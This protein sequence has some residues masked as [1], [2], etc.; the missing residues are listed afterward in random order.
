MTAAEEAAP[1]ARA[2][3]AHAGPDS[4]RPSSASSDMSPGPVSTSAVRAAMRTTLYSYPPLAAHGPLAPCTLRIAVA[5]V[6]IRPAAASGVASP[7]TTRAPPA[8]SEHACSERVAA[9]RVEVER[10][11]HP[12]VPSGPGHRTS[13]TAS[14]AVA[15]EERADATRAASLPTCMGPP[16]IAGRADTRGR[17]PPNG[18]VPAGRRPGQA[19]SC[20]GATEADPVSWPRL[21]ARPASFAPPAVHRGVAPGADP[22]YLVGLAAGGRVD[23][24]PVHV[25][26]TDQL[27]PKKGEPA[28]ALVGPGLPGVHLA[29]RPADAVAGPSTAPMPPRTPA[30]S[31][32]WPLPY[33]LGRAGTAGQPATGTAWRY[34]AAVRR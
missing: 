5:I 15:D 32:P 20:P 16:G 27:G 11:H 23:V 25:R 22:P 31:S 8:V 28:Q 7:A 9:R 18:T 12:S 24:R 30:S 29:R 17:T 2:A 3:S 4:L 14:C 1:A 19:R 21:G 10:G 33:P 6:P 34:G 26:E 13:R